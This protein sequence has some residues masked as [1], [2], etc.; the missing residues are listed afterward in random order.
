MVEKFKMRTNDEWRKWISI[1]D[2]KDTDKT[3]GMSGN[4][5]ILR[6]EYVNSSNAI[7]VPKIILTLKHIHIDEN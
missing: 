7:H 3:F 4:C 5:E 6:L 2:S 1:S